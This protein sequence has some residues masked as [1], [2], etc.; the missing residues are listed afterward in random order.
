MA[1]K[2]QPH[3]QSRQRT[4]CKDTGGNRFLH[5]WVWF[6][7]VLLLLLSAPP[8]LAAAPTCLR[9]H[10][11][12]YPA[13]GTCVACHRGN[14]RAVRMA[15]AHYEL[16]PGRLAGF[17]LPGNS[18]VAR[19]KRLTDRLACRRCHFLEQR[20][21]R[22]ASDLDRVTA[23][24]SLSRL[25]QAVQL[26]A[27]YM[28]DFRLAPAEQDEL[29]AYLIFAGQGVRKGKARQEMSLVVHF[30][31]DRRQQEDPFNRHCGGCHLTLTE[32]Q[33]GLGRGRV[34]PNLAGLLGEFYPRTST[35]NRPWTS[36]ALRAWLNNPRQFRPLATM[37][38][39]LLTARE[40]AELVHVML[41]LPASR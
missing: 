41:P 35:G 17:A 6:P 5:V 20:G 40:F 8:L 11:A 21:N 38:P 7:L 32:R 37:P 26:P 36:H 14:D 13:Q 23:T 30:A 39:V 33:G 27:W 9:C 28:P 22:L 3:S 10:P 15:L 12:H 1:L 31:D 19:G 4:I 18:F 25:R 24:M 16:L 2:R 34:A 29:L